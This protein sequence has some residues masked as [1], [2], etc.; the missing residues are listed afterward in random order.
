MPI[1]T[2]NNVNTENNLLINNYRFNICKEIKE[3]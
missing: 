1:C 2:F 3:N